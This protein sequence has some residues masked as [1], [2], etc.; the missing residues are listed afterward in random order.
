MKK[1]TIKL[2]NVEKLGIKKLIESTDTSKIYLLQNEQK[3]KLYNCLIRE[4]SKQYFNDSTRIEK[5]LYRQVLLE[6]NNVY[7]FPRKIVLD[8]FEICGY[9]AQFEKGEP[10]YKFTGT[11]IIEKLFQMLKKLE[12]ETKNISDIGLSIRDCH[13][14]NILISDS[15]IKVIDT[16]LYYFPTD[17]TQEQIFKKNI[18]SVFINI[19]FYLLPDVQLSNIWDNYTQKL[20]DL[21]CVGSIMMTDFLEH[22]ISKVK[23]HGSEID[24]LKQLTKSYH[25]R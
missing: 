20:Y 11:I 25:R 15:D 24:T 14:G 17:K 10:L 19:I 2:R 6:K 13:G 9:L 23:H 7:S 3:F 21:A 18:E 12:T 1:E 4:L 5:I 16:D 8:E 22:I